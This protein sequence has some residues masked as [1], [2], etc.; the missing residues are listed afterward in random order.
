[1]LYLVRFKC[2]ICAEAGGF[3]GWT[4][5][6]KSVIGDPT[7]KTDKDGNKYSMGEIQMHPIFR[8]H[9]ILDPWH[10]DK[11]FRIL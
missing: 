5:C 6:R 10:Y 2:E 3:Q 4:I 9:S 7:I 1:M 8:K 11:A